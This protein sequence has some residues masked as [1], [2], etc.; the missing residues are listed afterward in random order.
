MVGETIRRE[1]ERIALTGG[2]GA[3]KPEGRSRI[4]EALGKAAMAPMR[5]LEGDPR[6]GEALD[7]FTGQVK[8]EGSTP[9]ER[10]GRSRAGDSKKD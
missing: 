6:V 9:A 4:L 10:G 8:A 5:A 2:F 7:R 3:P 1:A